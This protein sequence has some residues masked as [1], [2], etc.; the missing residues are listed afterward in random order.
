VG[1]VRPLTHATSPNYIWGQRSSGT[2]IGM[3]KPEVFKN[4]ISRNMNEILCQRVPVRGA[5]QNAQTALWINHKSWRNT[6]S[7]QL[8]G[9]TGPIGS[10]TL[11]VFSIASKDAEV[12]LPVQKVI[13]WDDAAL[14]K[15]RK[16]ADWALNTGKCK[17]AHSV[18]EI[19]YLS[20]CDKTAKSIAFYGIVVKQRF[21]GILKTNTPS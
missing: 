6:E 20:R 17:V 11:H 18:Q 21:I 3:L 1:A 7:F 19:C 8:R 15:V 14:I 9:P 12:K 5:K 2:H 16:T 4:W 10:C 13:K